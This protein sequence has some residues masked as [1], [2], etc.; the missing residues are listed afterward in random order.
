M[1]DHGFDIRRD[2]RERRQRRRT[3]GEPFTNRRGSVTQFIKGIG[4]FPNLFTQ[5][6]HFCNTPSIVCNRPVSI[7]CHRDPHRCQ[8]TN[9]GN[10]DPIDVSQ[11]T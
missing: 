1:M 4:D 3:N 11:F 5:P 2:N 9:S 8:H 10:A 7:N 6:G